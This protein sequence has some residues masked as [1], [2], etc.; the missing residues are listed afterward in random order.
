L[1]VSVTTLEFT[2]QDGNPVSPVT[3]DNLVYLSSR[4]AL[5]DLRHF[6]ETMNDSHNLGNTTKWISFG[7]SYPGM[8]A[9]WARL[10]Y[11]KLVHAAVSNSAPIQMQVDFSLYKDRVSYD[12]QYPTVGGT[13][14]CL[15]VVLDGHYEIVDALAAGYHEEIASL[16]HICDAQ[17]LLIK[18]N[19]EMWV[20][21]GVIEIPAQ[22]NDPACDDLSCNIKKVGSCI[23]C[24]LRCVVAVSGVTAVPAMILTA[25]TPLVFYNNSSVKSFSRNIISLHSWKSL[26]LFPAYKRGMT[27]YF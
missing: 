14:E 20:G 3:N 4:F 10:E 12:L 8:L 23:Q 21:D 16:F 15:Q 17:S 27:V 26:P 5:A 2:D 6:L 25:A 9:A 18:S 19:V 1:L 7:G 11:P 13:Q 22:G 24:N